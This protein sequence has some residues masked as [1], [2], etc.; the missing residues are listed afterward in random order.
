MAGED[1]KNPHISGMSY[2]SAR[3]ELFLA[4]WNNKVVRAMRV[5]DNAGDLPDVY[6]AP[7]DMSPWIYSVCHM[8]NWDTLLVCSGDSYYANWLVALSRNGREWHEAHRLQI[9]GAGRI[10]CALSDSSLSCARV[11]IGDSNST[12]MELFRVK[13]HLFHRKHIERV[14]RIDVPEQYYS[15]SATCGS[16]TL[17]AMSYED[18]SVRVHRLQGDRLEELAR[19]QLKEPYRLLWLADRLLFAD[20]DSEKKSHAVIELEVSDTRLERRREVITSSEHIFV[21][22]W[23]VVKDG[24]AVFDENFILHYPFV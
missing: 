19:I 6:R 24:V 13:S 17:V 12:Y 1:N 14:H 10:S 2:N 9:E 5:R 22:S 11:L 15:F 23:C 20:Y 7:H 3:D 4:D 18:Q 16:D 8:S 21:S